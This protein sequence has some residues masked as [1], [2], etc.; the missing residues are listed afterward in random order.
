MKTSVDPKVA[1]E[2][3]PY[4]GLCFI[5]ENLPDIHFV[6]NEVEDDKIC[7]IKVVSDTKVLLTIIGIYM[8]YYDSSTTR[9]GLHSETLENF[10][11]IVDINDS[12]LML[13][14]SMNALLSQRDHLLHQWYKRHPFNCHGLLLYD[15]I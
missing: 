1:L 4:D 15:F 7:I 13:V 12:S 10:Q 3:C 5:Y 9:V 6:N 8:P 11:H 14:N 2:G